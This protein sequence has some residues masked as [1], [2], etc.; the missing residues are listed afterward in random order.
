[1]GLAKLREKQPKTNPPSWP[2][3][4]EMNIEDNNSNNNAGAQAGVLGKFSATSMP[5][6][7]WWQA[8]W[9]DPEGVLRRIGVD[10]GDSVLDICCGDGHF[11][12]PLC[13]IVGRSGRV[14]AM[15]IDAHMLNLAKSR[16]R[17]AGIKADAIDWLEQDARNIAGHIPRVPNFILIANTFHG[18]DNKPE[19]LR[20]VY[21]ALMPGGRFAVI[22][23]HHRPKSETT[24]LGQPRGPETANRMTPDQV[25]DLASDAGF[26][27]HGV[28]ELP[29]YHYA[30]V[31]NKRKV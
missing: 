28:V 22:N 13:N 4:K 5:D 27:L 30:A 29:P 2:K 26:R 7:D 3:T 25:I 19:F 1:M 16:A 18:V 8:L 15:D 20:E 21:S 23:W 17:S 9:P 31:F 14:M 10:F 11:T 12:I 24:V 6:A